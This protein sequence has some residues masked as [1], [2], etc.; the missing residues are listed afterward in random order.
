[1]NLQTFISMEGRIGRMTWWLSQLVMSLV[2]IIP[3]G[4]IFGILY[5][6][7]DFSLPEP[8]PSGLG[9]TLAVIIGGIM[10]VA[11]IWASIVINAKRWHDHDR[12]GWYQLLAMIPFV[13]IWV[14]IKSGFLRGTEGPNRF[15]DDPVGN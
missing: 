9:I 11:L 14:F 6:T 8:K 12:S 15:G 1:M 2:M 4:L 10:L 5:G 13:N 7:T 3:Y